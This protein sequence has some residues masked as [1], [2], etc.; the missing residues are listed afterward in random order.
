MR[1]AVLGSHPK[2]VIP[3]FVYEK[4]VILASTPMQCQITIIKF[5]NW[6]HDTQHNDPQHNEIQ[7]K[8]E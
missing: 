4:G 3:F 7:R 6:H 8:N 1:S 5:L 2:V